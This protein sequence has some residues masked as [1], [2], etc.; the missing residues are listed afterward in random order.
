M[1][2]CVKRGRHFLEPFFVLALPWLPLKSPESF[3]IDFGAQNGP[4]GHPQH[5]EIHP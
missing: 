1:A 5:L 4:K 3:F 2:D